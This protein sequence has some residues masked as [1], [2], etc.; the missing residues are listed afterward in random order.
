MNQEAETSAVKEEIKDSLSRKSSS[1]SS[2]SSDY[3][4]VAGDN[5]KGLTSPVLEFIVSENDLQDAIAAPGNMIN[6]PS[7]PNVVG[8][9]IFYDCLNDPSPL[10]EN[11]SFQKSDTDEGMN[12][13]F[14]LSVSR[15]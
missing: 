13:C 14:Y 8:K 6:S 12:H 2:E 10:N 5:N 1:E 9:S 11:L 4:V 7:T 3:V 15:A